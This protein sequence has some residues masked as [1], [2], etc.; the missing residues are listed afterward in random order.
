MKNRIFFLFAAVVCLSAGAAARA[1]GKYEITPFVGYETSGSYPVSVFSSTGGTLNPVDRL[2]VNDALSFGTFLDRSLTDSFQLEFMWIR[3]NTSYSER[4]ITNNTYSKAFSSNIDQYQFGGLF[5][6]LNR[7]RKLR[8]YVAA[9]LGFTHD[10]NT[11]GT[12]N[13]TAFAYSFGGGVKYYFDRH[14]GLRGDVRY[15]P[16]YANSSNGTFCDPLF[17]CYNARVRNYLKRGSFSGGVIF[18]F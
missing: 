17:G 5:M 14:I 12:P 18:H 1:Q 7:D 6:L 10:S 13:R 15:L 8:P 9:S 3:N 2:R 11:L 16:T 4:S